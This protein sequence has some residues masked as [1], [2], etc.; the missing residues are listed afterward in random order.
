[1]NNNK[2][3]A[4][5]SGIGFTGVLFITFLILKLCGVITWSW[6][7]VCSPLWIPLAIA[8]SIVLVVL[9]AAGIAYLFDR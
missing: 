4:T 5:S 8:L 3:Q 2:Q 1:M 7:W 6:F 9:I